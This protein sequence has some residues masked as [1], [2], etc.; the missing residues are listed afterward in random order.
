MCNICD[1]YV[2]IGWTPLFYAALK[3]HAAVVGLLLQKGAEIS[4][5]D[6]VHVYN[7]AKPLMLACH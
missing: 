5:C 2:Q 3:G 7:A 6:E 1:L 4:I